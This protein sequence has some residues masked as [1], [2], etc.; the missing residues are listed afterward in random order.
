[1]EIGD[2]RTGGEGSGNVVIRLAA[3][4][5]LFVLSAAIV[6]LS[7]QGAPSSEG[8]ETSETRSRSAAP[9]VSVE[10]GII[11][12]ASDIGVTESGHVVVADRLGN[13]VHVFD[14]VG[15]LVRSIGRLGA[16]PSEFNSPITLEVRADSVLVVDVGN[17]R[18]QV[19]TLDGSYVRTEGLPPSP[20][21]GY[22]DIGPGT[23][24]AG[25]T[26]GLDST[27]AK[28][29][30]GPTEL[31]SRI[32][33][34]VGTVSQVI[35]PRAMK[36]DLVNGTIP[37]LFLN[38]VRPVFGS[39]GEVWLVEPARAVVERFE[40]ATGERLDSVGLS[41]PG[42]EQVREDFMAANAELPG[43]RMDP[44]FFLLG[45]RVVDGDLWVL[46]ARGSEV[47][48][49]LLAVSGGG[50]V[51]P[52]PYEMPL[53]AILFAVDAARKRV[54]VATDLAELYRVES[55]GAAPN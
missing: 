14:S 49:K 26:L 39:E 19:V 12:E 23:L 45:G 24:T 18:M 27:L 28:V 38:T 41:D 33:T 47:P 54:Y 36:R 10:S 52:L 43:T 37:T 31:V 30:A 42:F 44:P 2:A 11:G 16:G 22:W 13:A 20:R 35:R 15:G 3:P 21:G 17:A 8:N 34:P 46:V 48:P 4:R 29:F 55:T 50:E 40:L 5:L 53:G 7:C 25:P 6:Q 9:I 32:G 1:M 51:R